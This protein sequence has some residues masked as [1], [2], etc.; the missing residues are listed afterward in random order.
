MKLTLIDAQN[1]AVERGG[2]CLSKKYINCRTRM[3]W[4]CKSGHIWKAKY[5]SI[6]N[7]QWCPVCATNKLRNTIQDAQNLAKKNGGRCLSKKYVN[8]CTKMRW[9]CEGG[10]T[11]ETTYTCIQQGKWCP[12]CKIS[13]PQKKLSII[14]EEII[15][16]KSITIRPNWLRNPKTNYS[17]L[18]AHH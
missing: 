18:Y 7:G 9:E 3:E 5:N 10:H 4:R 1:S 11:W 17:L 6:R 12:K 15:G 14:L 16:E 13:K 2:K 8:N